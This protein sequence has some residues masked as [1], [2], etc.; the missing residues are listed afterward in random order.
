MAPKYFIPLIPMII[1]W[2]GYNIYLT[3][4]KFLFFGTIFL[5]IVN[6]IYFWNDIP[7]DRPPMR[8]ALKIVYNENKNIKKIYTTERVAFNH[9]LSN[10]KFSKKHNFEIKKLR[11]FS[12]KNIEK[13]F[14]ILC[15]N[16]PR[17]AVGNLEIKNDQKKCT[18]SHKRENFHLTKTAKISD[19]IIYFV[20]YKK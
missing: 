18:D 1:L 6:S 10:Y 13:E 7:I 11:N 20:N 9:F 8:E 15:L 19:F 3:K 12:K 16:N 17:F 5:A 14:A 2:I 4:N